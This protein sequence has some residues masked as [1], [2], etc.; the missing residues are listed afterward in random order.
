MATVQVVLVVMLPL[1]LILGAFTLC[2]DGPGAATGWNGSMC[3]VLI[4]IGAGIDLGGATFD[5]FACD[6]TGSRGA[7]YGATPEA[8]CGVGSGGVIRGAVI[9]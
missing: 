4:V 5:E 9:G 8:E 3:G 2:A 1:T 6:A 7:M